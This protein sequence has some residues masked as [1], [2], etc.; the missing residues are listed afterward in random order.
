MKSLQA[1]PN[2]IYDNDSL[3]K[4]LFIWR[5]QHKKIVFT[6]GVFD[7]LHAGHIASISEAAK[8]GDILI[9]GINDDASVKRLK[10]D[11]RPINTSANRAIL[12][13][14]LVQVDAVIVFDTDTPYELIKSIMPNVLVK[15]GDYTL[16]QIV[17]SKEVI[18]AGGLVIIAKIVEGLSST[19]I[20]EKLNN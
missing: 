2:K 4:Q 15:G 11:K 6:N 8:Y 10:G 9:V 3:Q 16:E 1:I 14:S 7:V 20:I 12:L 18:A 13:A 17:G 5:M 19:K